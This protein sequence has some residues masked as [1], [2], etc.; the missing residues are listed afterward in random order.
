MKE[1]N[2]SGE[3]CVVDGELSDL[4][5]LMNTLSKGP[6]NVSCVVNFLCYYRITSRISI[7][8]LVFFQNFLIFKSYTLLCHNR[9]IFFLDKV[10]FYLH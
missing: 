10:I 5:C 1:R 4:R 8:L 7:L 6:S 9:I 2:L 3:F